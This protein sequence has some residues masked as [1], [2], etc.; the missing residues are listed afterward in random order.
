MIQDTIPQKKIKKPI[1][2]R[3]SLDT[4]AGFC[5][6]VDGALK[7]LM[8]RLQKGE[9]F[10]TDGEIIHNTTA[11]TILTNTGLSVGDDDN[12]GTPV[13]RTHSTSIERLRAIREKHS[14]VLN[15]SCKNVS[16]VQSCV[17]K[18]ASMG[19]H[20]IISG[21]RTHPEVLS[22]ASYAPESQVSIVQ[23]AN[24]ISTLPNADHYLLVSQTTFSTAVFDEIA[25]ELSRKYPKRITIIPTICNAAASRQSR[26]DNIDN[27]IYDTVIVVGGKQSSNTQRLAQRARDRG[28]ITY[29]IE[30]ADEL[31]D[32]LSK[33]KGIYL[34]AGASTPPWVIEECMSKARLLRL[35][36]VLRPIAYVTGLL[37]GLLHP[38]IIVVTIAAIVANPPAALDVFT[39]LFLTAISLILSAQQDLYRRFIS[40]KAMHSLLGIPILLLC[41]AFAMLSMIMKQ[42]AMPAQIFIPV[43]VMPLIALLGAFTAR[44]KGL[45]RFL[46]FETLFPASVA[47]IWHSTKLIDVTSA[48]IFLYALPCHMVIRAA[49]FDKEYLIERSP[50]IFMIGS[51]RYAFTALLIYGGITAAALYAISFY[52]IMPQRPLLAIALCSIAFILLLLKSA[53]AAH[54][55]FRK[56]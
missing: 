13:I 11:M 30:S 45:S 46:V 29:H 47:L 28:F 49:R 8:H 7:K 44:H 50:F 55:S 18:Y 35:P 19:Y 1:V 26:I 48:L 17:K 15:L 33:S 40:G 24:E 2:P 27:T 54:I 52:Q 6:G 4:E 3:L 9:Y 25:E 43:M 5:L 41:F 38:K 14:S 21:H 37:K 56:T 34:T 39:L 51:R 32:K 23:S 16:F 53:R 42:S 22:V 31:R 10:F 20:C 12:R 36:G